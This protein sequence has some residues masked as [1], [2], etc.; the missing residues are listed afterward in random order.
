MFRRIFMLQT[1]GVTG[2]GIVSSIG[3]TIPQFTL[4]LRHGNTGISKM[5]YELVPKTSVDIAALIKNFV[6]LEKLS[7]LNGLPDDVIRNAKRLGQRAPF[8]IQTSILST[9]EAWNMAKLF[10]NDLASDRIGL[11]IASQNSTQ[12]YQYNQLQKFRNKPEYLSPRY[13]LEFLETN[14]VGVLSELFHINGESLLI[15]GASATGNVGLIKAFQAVRTG[16]LDICVVVGVVTDL[17]PMDIQGFYNMGAMGGRKFS[18]QPD[19]A[20][21]PFD[22]QHEGFI[23]GQSGACVIIESMDSASKRNAEVLAQI[24]GGAIN[25]DGNSSSNPNVNGEMKAMLTALEQCGCTVSDVDYVNTHGSSSPLG[26]R[27]EAEAIRRV[28]GDH[29]SRVWLNSTKG[30][31]GHCLFS[32]GVVETI[33]TII[34]MNE[35]FLHPNKNIDEPIDKSLRFCGAKAIDDKINVAL[36]NSFGFGGINTSIALRRN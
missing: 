8:V 17:S 7:K 35:G 5:T 1:V 13:G 25:I 15:G 33:A 28:L 19:K 30:L 10:D 23:Y 29:S 21:R 4:S 22:I 6:F 27:T 12:N 14:Q 34:Q 24:A 2:M 20:C 11:F 26:D 31:T 16:I 3:D 32:A 36:S 9:L 18:D